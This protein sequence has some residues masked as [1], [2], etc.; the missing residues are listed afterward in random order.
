VLF[1]TP[2]TS[3]SRLLTTVLA[4]QKSATVTIPSDITIPTDGLKGAYITLRCTQYV[5]AKTDDANKI[6]FTTIT[7][8]NKC[9][10]TNPCGVGAQCDQ[11]TGQCQC[12]SGWLWTNTELAATLQQQQSKSSSLTLSTAQLLQ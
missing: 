11:R 12:K 6:T 4:S 9:P 10:T 3:Y 8:P 7:T 1:Y 5:T 2:T